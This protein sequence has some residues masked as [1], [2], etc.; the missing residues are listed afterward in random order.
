MTNMKSSYG[1]ISIADLERELAEAF[2]LGTRDTVEVPVVPIEIGRVPREVVDTESAFIE[3]A[4]PIP[5]AA[6][7]RRR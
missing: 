6:T 2:D 3:L 5:P 1:D 7:P 4:D